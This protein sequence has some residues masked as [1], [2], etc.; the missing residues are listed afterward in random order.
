M[1]TAPKA[2]VKPTVRPAGS[3]SRAAAAVISP[4]SKPVG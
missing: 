3:L 1:K 2:Y 4:E